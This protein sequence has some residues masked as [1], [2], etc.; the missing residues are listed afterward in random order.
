MPTMSFDHAI[1]LTAGEGRRLR[2]FTDSI[3]KPLIPFLGVPMVEYGLDLLKGAGV[4]H[5]VFNAY[6]LPEQIQAYVKKIEVHSKNSSHNCAAIKSVKV[7]LETTLMGG[8]GGL[9]AAQEFFTG[10]SNLILLNGDEV[11]FDLDM[12]A[13]NEGL[14]LHLEEKRLATVFV[15]EHPEV[16]TKFGGIWSDQRNLVKGFGLSAP[17]DSNEKLSGWHFY[18]VVALSSRIFDHIP[19]AQPANIFYDTLIN[20]LHLDQ[21]V[22]I[23]HAQCEHIETGNPQD[24]CDGQRLAFT[25]GLNLQLH[26]KPLL[27]FLKAQGF[28]VDLQRQFIAPKDF[29]L[30]KQI[31]CAGFNIVCENVKIADIDGI[32]LSDA[33][34]L[35][36]ATLKAPGRYSGLLL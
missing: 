3:A 7:S 33:V 28:A 24:L 9:K 26:G 2:P 30:P 17:K 31:Q 32:E 27:D 8:T 4:K 13:F 23:H 19:T 14:K 29:H 22:K 16:G 5:F 12:A 18:G 10:A 1:V 35:P 34:L 25:K 6:H 36:G 15:S 11:F 20:C 21:S